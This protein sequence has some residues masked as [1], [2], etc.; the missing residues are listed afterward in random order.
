V[1]RGVG[2]HE[3]QGRVAVRRQDDER[4]GA[5]DR[6]RIARRAAVSSCRPSST[7]TRPRTAASQV[8]SRAGESGPCSACE[9]RSEAT[10]AGIRGGVGHD[11]HFRRSGGQVDAALAEDLELGRG[12]P[13]VAGPD[14][15]IDRLDAGLGQP[16]GQRADRLR[17]AG[18]DELVH[19]DE[20]GG[21]EQRLVEAA[22]R[23]RGRGD[24]DRAPRRRPWPGR[25]PSAASW[26]GRG[27][28][29]GV[30][31]DTGQRH[32]AP[33]DLHA[34][35][36]RRGARL[37]SSVSAKRRMFS[38]ICSRPARMRG[39]SASRAAS[40]SARVTSSEPSARPPPNGVG[41][42]D[43]GVAAGLDRG[44]DGAGALANPRIGHGAAP[45]EGLDLGRDGRIGR[46]AGQF[47]AAQ[48][49]GGGWSWDELL[50]RQDEDAGGAGGL[51][52][53]QQRPDLR[54]RRRPSGWRSCPSC[55]SGITDGD[56]RPGRRPP[57][58]PPWRPARSSSGTC[59]RAPPAWRSASSGSS[60][61]QLGPVDLRAA[62]AS[63]TA[64]EA[65]T[66]SIGRRPLTTIVEPVETRSTIASARPSLGATSAAPETGMTSTGM[67]RD[68]RRSARQV[69]V[70]CGDAQ[71][72][73]I[74]GG[75]EGRVVR[76]RDRSGGTGRSRG[77]APAARPCPT[78]RP[79]PAR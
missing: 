35:H 11:H 57:A 16:V 3:V 42:A 31:A 10:C 18:D 33:L 19:S 1:L 23:V 66:S 26:V 43:G 64:S 34:R 52:A 49:H 30:D 51:E 4:A 73:Q 71:A 20:A 68:P 46:G 38:I 56:S 32:P 54:R 24:D 39:G 40:I 37:G 6:S 28:A 58:R 78:R 44:E 17:A 59:D 14:D 60:R 13:G 22:L 36:D 5:S 21:A 62:L 67:D 48:A 65:K 47:Q 74:L 70:R 29:R 27:A 50:D 25:R 9:S 61:P 8:T 72:G 15:P 75:P 63:R 79:G 76:D 53:G 2:V 77:C 55:A 12:H 7:S 41:L 45:E 69:H